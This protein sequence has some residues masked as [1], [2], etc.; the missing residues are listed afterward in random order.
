M[1][2]SKGPQHELIRLA[3]NMWGAEFLPQT[4]ILPWVDLVITHGGNNTV[5]ECFHFGKPMRVLPLFWD[6]PDNAQRVHELGYGVRFATYDFETR[7]F[8]AAVDRVFADD[9]LRGR[10][11][12]DLWALS[13][14][15]AFDGPILLKAIKAT[16]ARRAMAIES[17]RAGLEENF[18]NDEGKSAEWTAFIRR[19]R[20]T[21]APAR[22]TE[23]VSVVR[24]FAYPL[25]SAAASGDVFN[26][27]WQPG[28]PWTVEGPK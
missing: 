5:T 21:A 24:N 2:I 11:A 18:A 12:G 19:S 26:R 13:R 15:Y 7:E 4:S 14:L 10:T 22:F 8:L 9:N 27:T 6:Q 23:V 25:L 28:G 3:D 16:F 17:Q 1:I 20:L